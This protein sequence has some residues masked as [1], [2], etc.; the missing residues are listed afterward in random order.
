VLCLDFPPLFNLRFDFDGNGSHCFD[1]SVPYDPELVGLIL[2][3]QFIVC[4]PD[5]GVSNQRSLEIVDELAAGDF[6]T[7]TQD[8]ELGIHCKE[9]N[10]DGPACLLADHFATLFPDGVILGDQDGV[11]GDASLAIVLTSPDAVAKFL[12]QKGAIGPLDA[13]YTDPKTTPAGSSPASCSRPS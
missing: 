4:D 11:D 10:A 2:Y 5:P 9:D 8:G 3:A 1:T 7:C 13:D 12:P 6:V